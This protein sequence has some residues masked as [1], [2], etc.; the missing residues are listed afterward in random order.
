MT[1]AP[2]RP[3]SD[4]ISLVREA[5]ERLARGELDAFAELV[6]EDA[7]WIGVQ[8]E[9]G[10]EPATCAN[11]EEIV[12]TM[13]QNLAA[14]LHGELVRVVEGPGGV[15]VEVGHGQHGRGVEQEGGGEGERDRSLLVVQSDLLAVGGVAV[16]VVP[17]QAEPDVAGEDA[18]GIGTDFTQG[19]GDA[20]VEWIMRDKGTGR[21]LTETP[22][23]ELRVVMPRGLRTL[24][25]WPNVTAAM[26][27][28][29]WPEPRI[30]KVLG[31]NW[32][33]VLA[34]VWNA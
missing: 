7:T 2:D 23:A 14:S 15:A 8:P 6:A 10:A 18:V 16:E 19:H 26:E 28:R 33:R 5:H 9:D 29:R 30:R 11:R 34:D 25:E 22:L 27:R 31:G 4:D 17:A 1:D 32:L 21:L 3:S 20:F 24:D 12:E 13:R